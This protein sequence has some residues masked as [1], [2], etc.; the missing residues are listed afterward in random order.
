MHLRFFSEK[1]FGTWVDGKIVNRGSKQVTIKAY[2][3]GATWL[4]KKPVDTE[5]YY[6]QGHIN[7]GEPFVLEK[8]NKRK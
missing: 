8:V 3:N 1:V 5:F 7:Q 2:F 6:P 4:E